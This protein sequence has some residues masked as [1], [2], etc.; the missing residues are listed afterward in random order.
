MA[1]DPGAPAPTGWLRASR[2]HPSVSAAFDAGWLLVFVLLGRTSHTEGLTVPG[3]LR[4]VWPF[5]VGLVIGWMVSRAWRAPAALIPTGV[6]IWPVCVAAA[7][8][9][10]AISGQ[11]VA[12]R[13]SGW[14]WHSSASGCSVGEPWPT[15]SPSVRQSRGSRVGGVWPRATGS[16]D[17]TSRSPL[18]APGHGNLSDFVRNFPKFS[19]ILVSGLIWDVSG[20]EIGGIGTG[21]DGRDG[22]GAP[23]VSEPVG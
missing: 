15:S 3:V 2:V 23:G 11:G 1:A 21:I 6:E 9:L 18:S 7:M 17:L 19:N 5:W 16:R 13:S 8:A 22:P 12:P 14:P 10:R 20:A 4:T